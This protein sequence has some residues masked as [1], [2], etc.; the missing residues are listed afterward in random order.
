MTSFSLRPFS[1]EPIYDGRRW[2]DARRALQRAICHEGQR[3]NGQGHLF[4]ISSSNN[5]WNWLQDQIDFHPFSFTSIQFNGSINIHQNPVRT[6]QDNG[7]WLN[8]KVLYLRPWGWCCCLLLK[9]SFSYWRAACR[10]LGKF[11]IQISKFSKHRVALSLFHFIVIIFFWEKRSFR[12]KKI[13]F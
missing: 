11:L 1:L 6:L 5:A 4:A 12:T 8:G 10:L 13:L 7:S 9:R 2:E 3:I